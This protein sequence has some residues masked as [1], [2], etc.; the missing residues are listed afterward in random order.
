MTNILC[1]GDGPPCLCK[2]EHRGNQCEKPI[3]TG[4]FKD[5]ENG[6]SMKVNK[7]CGKPAIFREDANT[8]WE[9]KQVLCNECY[10][11]EFK[12]ADR[13]CGMCNSKMRSCC[14]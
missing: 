4:E 7:D 1:K 9:H 12:Y 3:F 14:C 10:T 5:N 2:A 11:E 13:R 8:F 6:V